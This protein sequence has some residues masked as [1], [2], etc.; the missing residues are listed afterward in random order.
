M[1]PR[2]AER[3]LRSCGSLC[4]ESLPAS[5]M[6]KL[7]PDWGEGGTLASWRPSRESEALST[8]CA[9]AVA[10]LARAV[11]YA[12]QRGVLHR[13]LKPNNV[14]V[15]AS[16][17]L[18]LTDF[19]LARLLERE[20]SVTRTSAI[21]GTPSYMAPEQAR[22]EARQLTTA[23]DVYGL[24][25]ILYE[26]L[27]GRPPFVGDT[28][29]ATIRQ[30]VDQEPIP[31]RQLR[32]ELERDLE[33]ICLKCL[34]KE[35][36]RR[37]TS[38]EALADELTRWMRHEP[39]LARPAG[40]TERARK[41]ARRHPAIAAVAASL[42]VAISAIAVISTIAAYR[43]ADART[44]TERANV[45][46]GQH[47]RDLEWQKAE[48]R[49]EAGQIG[50]ALAYFGNFLRTAPDP[51]IPAARALSLL[52]LRSFPLPVGEALQHDGS[53]NDLDFDP[54]GERIATASQDGTLRVWRV[55]DQERLATL[56]QGAPVAV[57]R[58]HPGGK[59]VLAVCQNGEARLWDPDSATLVQE[60]PCTP[61]RHPLTEFSRDGRWLALRTSST[62]VT[63]FEV[64][65]GRAVL[66]P[67][68]HTNGLRSLGFTPDSREV[69]TSAHDG[70]IF[71]IEITTGRATL[72]PLRLQQ[73][74]SLARVSPN[75]LFLVSGEG[76]GIAVWDRAT[77]NRLREIATGRA[78]IIRLPFSP[79]SE[80]VL[81]CP[82]QEPPRI[83]DLRSG[84]PLSPPISAAR[85]VSDAAFSPDGSR[86]ATSSIDGLAHLW[87]G[88]TGAPLLKPLQHDG[89]ITR[90]RF[91]PDGRHLAT[92][93]ED[94]TAQLWDI[95][96]QQPEPRRIPNLANLREAKLSP[97]GNWL[98]T[99]AGPI[100]Q[101]R[102]IATGEPQGPPM[103]HERDVLEFEISPDGRR[104]V[105]LAFDD[106]A[107]IWDTSS[108]RELTPP[109]RH[110]DQLASVSFS[111]DGRIVGTTATDRTARLWDADS[112]APLCESLPHP[113]VPI[114]G[115]FHP[116]GD[117]FLTGCWDGRARMWSV[118]EGRL[119][120][121]TE[122]HEGRMWTFRFSPD[123]RWFATASA[124]R[125]VRLWDTRTGKPVG[126]ALLHQRGV[127]RLQFSPD[128]ARLATATDDGV[129]RVWDA[130]TGTTVSRPIRHSGDIYQ[131]VFS[132]DGN[133]IL[134]GSFDQTAR[135]W[136]A[137]TGFPLSEPLHHGGKLLRT[138]FTL[139]G[140]RVV[141]TAEDG[142]L[143]FWSLPN[144][145]S[146]VP[147]WLAGLA[148]ALGG[149]RFNDAGEME[150]VPVS[151]LPALRRRL[152]DAPTRDF[153]HN[154][155]RW[156][157]ETRFQPE[158]REF[159]P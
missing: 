134:T 103:L 126:R 114:H 81:T 71:A 28:T 144:P 121:E 131:L 45:R 139:D 67:L 142:V 49:V 63:V 88:R 109:L 57:A 42:S 94:R 79:D 156:F 147:Q 122:A 21:L 5:L 153:Y 74:A 80:R 82:F 104:L 95:G 148:E 117:R 38:A 41:W 101:R 113:D 13:D 31:P 119:L 44:L 29:M 150:G 59:W 65:T 106:A 105:A 98:F 158:A 4:S 145:P 124:D 128:G 130:V 43:L 33:T 35:P 154:W 18:F 26:L 132:P 72:P 53:V 83:W 64:A 91:S 149:K 102:A 69:V 100:V 115:A 68:E 37:Y 133:R 19:G 97:D 146:P 73:P 118:P 36:A 152:L 116:S 125:T 137:E 96:M 85:D 39:I 159:K 7:P 93:S 120:F 129:A 92:A 86:V 123:G 22:G 24:G 23:T 12:H 51:S 20:S 46:L 3:D 66:G 157:L 77:G 70:S 25:A 32:P 141:T 62:S 87:D 10:T 2:D 56:E 30:V 136:D 54:A 14:L 61:L 9:A 127:R 89:P 11:H 50:E 99:S 60:Y 16:G 143:R 55:A 15:D 8:A 1:R 155:A 78:E 76:G 27:T 47:V 40:K 90:L 17:T 135:L 111:P 151:D 75:G 138:L 84:E 110:E 107:H 140:Q 48:E 112:G 34:E 108:P 52:S 58:F 6:P